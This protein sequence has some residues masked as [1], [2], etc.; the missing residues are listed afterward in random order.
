MTLVL[1]IDE[2]TYAELWS[3]EPVTSVLSEGDA[4]VSI[5]APLTGSRIGVITEGA[6]YGRVVSVGI[7]NYALTDDDLSAF[8][9]DDPAYDVVRHPSKANQ[10]ILKP[11]TVEPAIYTITAEAETGGSIHPD[12]AVSVAAGGDQAFVITPDNDYHIADVLVDGVSAI[13]AVVAEAAAE[14]TIT[15]C[16][17]NP[18][19]APATKMKAALTVRQ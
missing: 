16:T 17:M 10:F 18:T 13:I 5:S 1:G 3:V 14:P 9:S 4:R 19:E 11:R 6:Q 8:T 2:E 7:S 12:G 15:S